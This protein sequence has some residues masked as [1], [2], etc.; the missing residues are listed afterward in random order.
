VSIYKIRGALLWLLQEIIE[1]RLRKC[2]TFW[3]WVRF[4]LRRLQLRRS[5]E[6]EEAL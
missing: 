2:H 4:L 1:G 6:Y 3:G 5:R